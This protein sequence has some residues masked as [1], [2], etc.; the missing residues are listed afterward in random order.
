MLCL[1]GKSE[2]LL[3]AWALGRG[4]DGACWELVLH[5]EITTY[6]TQYL[7]AQFLWYTDSYEIEGGIFILY[8]AVLLLLHL[9]LYAPCEMCVV[10]WK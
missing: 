8:Y 2:Q 5:S 4:L 6:N 10:Y 3:C 7:T 9:F 1:V